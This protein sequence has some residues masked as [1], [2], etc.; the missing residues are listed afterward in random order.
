MAARVAARYFGFTV[1]GISDAIAQTIRQ[2]HGLEHVP[3]VNNGIP[4]SESSDR[5]SSD[6]RKALGL[7]PDDI[8]CINVAS[9]S[10]RKNHVMLIDAFNEALAINPGLVLLL[11]GQG[12][13][14]R[15][16]RNMVEGYG[17]SGRVRFLGL[18]DDVMVLNA[19][20]DLFVLSSHCEGLPISALEAISAGLPVVATNVGGLRD[21]VREGINGRLIAPGDVSS[22]ADAIVSMAA[23][24]ELAR[25]MGHAGREFIRSSFSISETV[26]GHERL[27]S[28]LL[29]ASGVN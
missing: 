7:E 13:L 20:A 10:E 19:L 21:I 9:F 15:K 11:V 8:V 3:V 1:L 26:K 25:A 28:S 14:M 16:I 5:I 17:I 29:N 18:R 6:A 12:A 4:M 23:N 2:Y 24:R 22:F 27:Y